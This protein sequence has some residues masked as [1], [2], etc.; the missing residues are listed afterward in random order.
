MADEAQSLTG[1]DLTQGFEPARLNDGELLLGHANGEAVVI[2]KDAGECFAVSAKCTH[3]GGNLA[4]GILVGGAIRCPLH[5][6]EFCLRTGEVLT[7]PALDPVK[8]WALEIACT[9]S[10]KPSASAPH[11]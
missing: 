4:R 3:Y 6:A 10:A 8:S 7:P 5:H 9:L 2:A 11:K 1:P